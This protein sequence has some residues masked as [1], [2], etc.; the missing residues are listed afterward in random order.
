MVSG[1]SVS[2]DVHCRLALHECSLV[3]VFVYANLLLTTQCNVTVSGNKGAN[4]H[5]WPTDRQTFAANRD[6]SFE[7]AK[8][9]QRGTCVRAGLSRYRLVLI[10]LII[11]N[12]TVRAKR[13]WNW[14]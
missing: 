9:L 8:R 14:A 4:T 10:A 6:N 7:S 2:H 13:A 3:L 1:H 5:K 12:K 11:H